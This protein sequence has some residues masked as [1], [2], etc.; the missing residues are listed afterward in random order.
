MAS[1]SEIQWSALRGPNLHNRLSVLCLL[2][3]TVKIFSKMHV[4][5]FTLVK[6]Q[7]A[8]RMTSI[9]FTPALVKPL[10]H[11]GRPWSTE[12]KCAS[13]QKAVQRDGWIALIP[14]PTP[15]GCGK[16]YSTSQ[17]A[18]PQPALSAPQTASRLPATPQKGSIHT[19]GLCQLQLHL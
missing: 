19:L 13:C 10:P 6:P 15:G 7:T 4:I 18:G 14:L 1:D 5:R 3:V 17:T 16:A 12:L 8:C 11:P 2:Y 9:P